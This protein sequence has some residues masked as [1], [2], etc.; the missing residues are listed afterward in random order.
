MSDILKRAAKALN[1]AVSGYSSADPLTQSERAS[2]AALL[3]ALDPEDKALIEVVARAICVGDPERVTHPRIGPSG[4]VLDVA[5][6][7][8]W[9]Y[10]DEAVAALVALRDAAQ[11]EPS[12]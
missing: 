1:E 12:T 11:G 6:P 4:V 10:R 3:A 7:S 2:Q 8:W 9:N 5:I